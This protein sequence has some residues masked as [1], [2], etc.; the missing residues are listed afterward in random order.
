M[1]QLLA[2]K[3]PKQKIMFKNIFANKHVQSG[4][5]QVG[6]SGIA[7]LS[8][9]ILARTLSQTDFGQWALYLTLLT[10]VDMIKTGIVQSALIKY[11]SG[12]S[13]E[14]KNELIGSSWLLN[15]FTI[16]IITLV[17]YSI[18]FFGSFENSGVTCFLL[19]YPLY[20]LLSMPFFYFIW[21]HQ[22]TMEFQK[23]TVIVAINSSA[24]LLVC[25]ATSLVVFDLE[26]L[27]LCNIGAFSVSSLVALA[28][29]KTGI[30]KIVKA[31]KH[32]IKKFIAFGKYHMLAFLGSNL[33]KSSDTFII[34]AFLGPVAIAIYSIPLRLLMIIEMPLT[35]AIAVAF[36][37]F[38]AQDNQEKKQLLKESLEKYI[39]V[40][41]IAYV[42]FMALL[43]LFSEQLVLII[44]GEKYLSATPIFQIFLIYG[45]FLPFD[46]LTGVA[47]DSIGLPRL[48]FY[49]VLIMAL[50]NIIGDFIVIYFFKS[51][52]LVALVTVVNVLSG[53]IAGYILIRKHVKIEIQ[54][55]LKSGLLTI[56]NGIKKK[57]LNQK[58][59]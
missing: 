37:T 1:A 5:T 12:C 6:A 46:R 8:F 13:T 38:S 55:I 47:L 34:S 39:G 3:G 44:G 22:V 32:S 23:I 53:L 21:N 30:N 10:F 26:Q 20:A 15:L 57:E 56:V 58:F 52:E 48:N 7:V 35:S 59:N 2:I 50:V 19:F 4:V 40:L 25:I 31:T 9:M 17:N 29:G 27:I 41:T 16:G 28:W 42:P 54:S 24:F 49:K 51:L 11:S 43:F 14:K 36:P 18:Y 33:L 45:L